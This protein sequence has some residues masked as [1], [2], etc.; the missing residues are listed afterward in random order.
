ML[1]NSGVHRIGGNIQPAGPDDCLHFD[2]HLLEQGPIAQPCE[3]LRFRRRNQCGKI[4]DAPQP[5]DEP[6][7]LKVV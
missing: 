4:D 3:H 6:H 1:L 5:I 2:M 7:K